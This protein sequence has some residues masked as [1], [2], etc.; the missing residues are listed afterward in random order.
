MADAGSYVYAVTRTA[1]DRAPAD[2]DGAGGA[3]VRTVES[4]GLE[5][6]VST[7]G[8]AE[9]GE[10]ALRHNLEDL[11]WLEAVA[12]AH[13]GVV[14]GAA[15]IRPLVP[16]GLAT[17]CDGDDRVREWLDDKAATFMAALDLVEGRVEW[18]VKAFATNPTPR[19]G[20]RRGPRLMRR[21]A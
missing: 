18:G 1:A 10:E 9:F 5:A 15:K 2:L 20:P 6:L 17:I 4:G 11:A 19:W 8:W 16:L 21:P 3:P 7:V 13:H 14:D 12:R